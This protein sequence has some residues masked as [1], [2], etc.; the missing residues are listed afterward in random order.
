MN[1]LLIM[2]FRIR[3]CSEV[4]MMCIKIISYAAVL[5]LEAMM[6]HLWG[7]TPGKWLM[8][9]RLEDPNGGKLS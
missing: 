9:M 7:T 5:P 3:P 1:V 4:F 2:T 8:G 6:L